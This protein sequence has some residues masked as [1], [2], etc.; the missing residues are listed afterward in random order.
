VAIRAIEDRLC[1]LFTQHAPAFE[2][3]PHTTHQYQLEQ[4][5][6]SNDCFQLSAYDEVRGVLASLDG[7]PSPEF[8][9]RDDCAPAL[10]CKAAMC[11]RGLLGDPAFNDVSFRIPYSPVRQKCPRRGPAAHC[12]QQKLFIDTHHRIIPP[13]VS[14]LV[15]DAVHR[16]LCGSARAEESCR[17]AELV[18]A[19]SVRPL[20]H[21]ATRLAATP[22]SPR[23]LARAAAA[24]AD[25]GYDMEQVAHLNLHQLI[26][27]IHTSKL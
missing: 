7:L 10:R 23:A 25:T 27:D 11:V 2:E 24:H 17:A 19:P 16:R 15:A 9:V 13:H 6:T 14:Q 26:H 8:T 5:R 4:I 18:L 21:A 22:S 3:Y 1:Q 12:L 20:L